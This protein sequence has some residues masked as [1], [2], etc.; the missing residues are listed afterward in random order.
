MT[1][2]NYPPIPYRGYLL[3]PVRYSAAR[4]SC[5]VT[6]EDEIPIM[7]TGNLRSRQRAIAEARAMVDRLEAER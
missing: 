3:W 7:W 6:R 5:Y 1:E 2:E 4:W